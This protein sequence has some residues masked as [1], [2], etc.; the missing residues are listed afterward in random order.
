M[1]SATYTSVT[2]T[3]T[4]ANSSDTIQKLKFKDQC[5]EPSMWAFIIIAIIVLVLLFL[6]M[7]PGMDAY[8]QMNKK[9]WSD[10][11]SVWGIVIAIVVL[12]FAYGSYQG[13]RNACDDMSRQLIAVSFGVQMVLLLVVFYLGFRSQS[14]TN[15]FYLAIV[16]FL[17][18]I[19]HL[20]FVWKSSRG[21]GYACILYV[22]WTLLVL[23]GAWGVSG[24]NKAPKRDH[25]RHHH[26]Q[27]EDNV[28]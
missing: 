18:S 28:D 12:L 15:A 6:V 7:R 24:D 17:L 19:A 4:P 1:D 11:N 26:Q 27:Q 20:Y 2:E 23:L 8:N 25:H 10:A 3:V 5:R 13:Y 9:G 16:V 21:G 22:I 14:F